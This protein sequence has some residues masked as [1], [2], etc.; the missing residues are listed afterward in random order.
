[1]S[2]HAQSKQGGPE[3][4]RRGR[5]RRTHWEVSELDAIKL[6]GLDEV[7]HRKKGRMQ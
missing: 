1:M 2:G 7:G 3:N 6:G 4:W 5:E